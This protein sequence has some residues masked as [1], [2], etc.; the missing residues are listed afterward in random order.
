MGKRVEALVEPRL[1]LWARDSAG[2]TLEQAANKV[3]IKPERLASWESGTGLPTVNQLRKLGKAC[4]RP[5]GVFY[6]P[7]PPRVPEP[8]HDF[9][10]LPGE[11]ARVE[12]PELRL[13]IRRARGR[14]QI[15]LELYEEIE[16][17]APRFS[18]RARLSDDPEKLAA[19]IRGLLC[20]PVPDD[21]RFRDDYEA[22]NR[23]RSALEDTGVLVFQARGIDPAE[24]RGFSIGEL[25]LPVVVVNI[26]DSVRAR[27]F[28]ML[29]DF[30][31]LMLRHGGLCDLGETNRP[32]EEQRVEIFCN[33]VAG[34]VL[35]PKDDLLKQSLVTRRG[36]GAT[37]SDDEIV[38]LAGRY[39]ASR[40]AVLRR[41][42]ILGHT[43]RDFYERKRKGFREEYRARG[44][45]ARA[46]RGGPVPYR[47]A[48]SSAGRLFTRLVLHGYYRERITASD[49]S[50]FL[51][52]KLEH[53]G[54]IEREVIGHPLE[55]GAQL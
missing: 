8:L 53:M 5:V 26:K 46:L 39:R 48:I 50:G 12:S 3:R 49:L 14:R 32:P 47:I 27:I 22:L 43:T 29:H 11:T 45:S 38:E 41:L 37:W 36:E 30:V 19:R 7:E 1:L 52:V 20:M 55:F 42:L 21:L 25:P 2:L 16:G 18:A 54:K 51:N 35:V 34:A 10:R 9:R 4:N 24:M 13:E 23:W 31:H 17:E 44:E 6:L 28:T 40:E 33:R 15:A